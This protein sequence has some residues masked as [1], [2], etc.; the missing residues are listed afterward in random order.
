MTKLPLHLTALTHTANHTIVDVTQE[1]VDVIIE[2]EYKIIEINDVKPW[3]AYLVLHGDNVDIFVEDFFP[4]LTPEQARLG[5]TDAQLQP[6]ILIVS[7]KQRLSLQTHD[8]R[9]ERWLFLKPGLYYKGKTLEDLQLYE[10]VVGE[11]VQFEQGEIHRLCGN[12][13]G[14]VVVAEIW[15]HTDPENLSDED[16]IVRLEDDYSR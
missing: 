7:P 5:N 14:F 4:S 11:E 15:Q 3:G 13:E 8:R 16:D 2:T 1:I 6:K 12:K 9:A 10:G